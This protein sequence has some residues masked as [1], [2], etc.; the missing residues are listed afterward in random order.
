M[1]HPEAERRAIVEAYYRWR[2]AGQSDQR[3]AVEL[4]QAHG[5]T[6]QTLYNY[7]KAHEAE[8]RERA[9]IER[10]DRRLR[11]LVEAQESGES[12]DPWGLTD[13]VAV[14]AVEV[15]ALRSEIATIRR[16]IRQPLTI[17]R[18]GSVG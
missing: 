15:G 17:T 16:E 14:L 5:I 4:A 9:R 3:T 10:F 7:V 12:V 11:A 13:A 8:Q 18:P 6:K 2:L 1:K